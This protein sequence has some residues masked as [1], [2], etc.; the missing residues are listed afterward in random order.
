MEREESGT[1]DVF[2]SSAGVSQWGES[3]W[4]R[5]LVCE[6]CREA[7]HGTFSVAIDAADAR[8]LGPRHGAA[9]HPSVLA[10][11]AA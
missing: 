9:H 1:V 5:R 7:V 2:G 4:L 11:V 3:R 10:V 6:L 8:V